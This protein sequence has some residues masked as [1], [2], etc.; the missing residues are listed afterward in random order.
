MYAEVG[1]RSQ[2]SPAP[3][4]MGDSLGGSGRSVRSAG[5]EKEGGGQTTVDGGDRDSDDDGSQTVA[6]GRR[7]RACG[8]V[9][10]INF[11][12]LKGYRPR[13]GLAFGDSVSATPSDPNDGSD[14]DELD[15]DDDTGQTAAAAAD[16]AS[17]EGV[18]TAASVTTTATATKPMAGDDVVTPGGEPQRLSPSDAQTVAAT[19]ELVGVDDA[20]EAIQCLDTHF[21]AWANGVAR[22]RKDGR[23]NG[24][25]PVWPMLAHV[26]T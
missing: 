3:M 10:Y 16:S 24:C 5:G 18:R 8:R 20:F 9:A 21:S 22:A 1:L 17:A 7:I 12:Y 23:R 11:N 14:C 13:I 2:N 4:K 26:R 6:R 25:Y 19:V 15:P